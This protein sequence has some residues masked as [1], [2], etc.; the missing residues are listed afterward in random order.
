[1]RAPL[2]IAVL[3]PGC[4]NCRAL[5]KATRRA[6]D[7]LGLDAEIS[8]VTDYAA[9]AALGVLATP[10]LEVDGQVVLSG[11]VPSVAEVKDLL[12]AVEAE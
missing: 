8:H 5:E 2:Q 7:E 4:R 3:G 9:I 6:L 10:G 12:G 11:R 1:M